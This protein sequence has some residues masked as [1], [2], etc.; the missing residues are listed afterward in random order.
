MALISRIYLRSGAGLLDRLVELIK[1]AR[2]VDSE[3]LFKRFLVH[4]F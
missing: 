4:N 2:L 1:M 3:V